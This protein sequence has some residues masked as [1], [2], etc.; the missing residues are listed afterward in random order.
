MRTFHV[1][2]SIQPSLLL[3]FYL[4]A[5]PPRISR[6]SECK[7]MRWQVPVNDLQSPFIS[8]PYSMPVPYSHSRPRIMRGQR[9]ERLIASHYDMSIR[10]FFPQFPTMLSHDPAQGTAG[11]R[12]HVQQTTSSICKSFVIII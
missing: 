8:G 9:F 3:Q 10:L 7:F 4:N 1:C 6:L 11:L 2:C 12:N 5:R